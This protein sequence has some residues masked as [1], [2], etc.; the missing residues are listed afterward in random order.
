VDRNAGDYVRI[1]HAAGDLA[2]VETRAIDF[3]FRAQEAPP[4]GDIGGLLSKDAKDSHD[5]DLVVGTFANAESQF[6]FM[7]VQ[8]QTG[9]FVRCSQAVPMLQWH[10]VAVSL[11]DDLG[12][13][14][15]V[16]GMLAD[17]VIPVLD[18]S[19]TANVS[20]VNVGEEKP[21]A[22]LT[23]IDNDNDWIWGASN[24]GDNRNDPDDVPVSDVIRMSVDELRFRSQ[25]FAPGEAQ[26]VY[27]AVMGGAT[28][29]PAN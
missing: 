29:P 22:K 24:R 10:H 3:W 13:T 1:P 6:V 19:I 15:Y 8:S 16:D 14:L 7:Q 4:I 11:D 28:A 17:N 21:E 12:A 27:D 18:S 25:P 20:C 9:A 26:L 5:G 2:L 23:L